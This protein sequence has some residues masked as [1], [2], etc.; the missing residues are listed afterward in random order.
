LRKSRTTT[1]PR[2]TVIFV[3]SQR[4][5][6]AALNELMRIAREDSDKRMR[7]RAMFWLGQKDDPRVTNVG[8]LIRRI[9]FDELPQL[10]NV[11]KGEM[12]IVGPRPERPEFVRA[13]NEQ[14]PYYRQR[15]CV[16]PGITGWAQ[17]NYKYGDTLEDTITKLEYDLYYIKNMSIA[18]SG[19]IELDLSF[20]SIPS[21]VEPLL[22][23]GLQ[24]IIQGVHFKC[25]HSILIVCSCKD[26]VGRMIR[27]KRFKYLEATDFRHLNVEEDQIGRQRLDRLN[28]LSAV[29][30]FRYNF[31]F[32][33][34][35]EHFANHVAR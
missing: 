18:L 13:L 4:Q 24:Q 16:R 6:E 14:I 34:A 29:C 26:D 28:R 10:V 9:R 19:A 23:E 3:L 2:L 27:F 31:Y 35:H 21:G 17:I 7:S 1:V 25:T 20:G 5:D 15:H 32:G 33:I 22:I 8:R 12:A 30:A 11:L